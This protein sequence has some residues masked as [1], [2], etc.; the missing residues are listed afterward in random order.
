MLDFDHTISYTF[1]T[2]EIKNEQ[3]ILGIDIEDGLEERYDFTIEML[4]G[5]KPY[6]PT[7]NDRS[8]WKKI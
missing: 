2:D 5:R 8:Y 7:R 6:E 1:D 3:S 4:N